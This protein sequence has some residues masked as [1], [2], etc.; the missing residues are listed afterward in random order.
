M[1]VFPYSNRTET[2]MSHALQKVSV[3]KAL[4]PRREPY[5]AAPL[6]RGKYIGLR[7]I[8]AERATW[9]ARLRDDAGRQAY[10]SIGYA[11]DVLE[12][13]QAKAAAEAWFKTRESGVT[14][15]VVTVADACRAY[16]EDRRREKGDA[17]AHDAE[18]RNLQCRCLRPPRTP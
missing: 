12:F 9:I 1:V 7:K 14:D 3:R 13:D 2:A 8:D 17:T 11:T 10:H 16:V 18:K 6:A 5:W 4:Q 15:Q